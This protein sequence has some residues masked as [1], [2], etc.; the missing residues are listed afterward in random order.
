MKIVPHQ[1]Y[2]VC[3]QINDSKCVV[4]GFIHYEKETVPIYKIVDVS[5]S[6]DNT[7]FNTNDEVICNSTGTKVSLNDEFYYVF[8]EENIVGKIN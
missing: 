1:K 4:D 2:I 6:L 8:N 7:R 3:K 5:K